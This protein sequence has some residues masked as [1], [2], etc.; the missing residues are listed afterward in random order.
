MEKA[1]QDLLKAS[2]LAGMAEVATG[3]LHNVGN[4]LNS[5]N[6]SVNYLGE[7]LRKSKVSSLVRA[8]ALLKENSPRLADYLT[9]DPKGK[10]LPGYL[11]DISSYLAAEN[12]TLAGKMDQ[13]KGHVE[14]V[15][16]IVAMQQD[17]AK[18]GGMVESVRVPDLVEDALRLNSTGLSRH[19]IE[20]RREFEAVPPILV[21]KHRVLQILVNLVR[22]AEHACASSETLPR[23]LVMRVESAEGRVRIGVADNGVG[24]PPENMVR[25]FNHGFTTRKDGHG[26][27]LHSCALTARELGG[28]LRAQSGGAGRG[29]TF[30]LDLP[31]QPLR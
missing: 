7:A 18:V 30:T 1:N 2:R 10:Q 5:V 12:E 26:F 15:K 27:G 24:I 20:V 8:T 21:D 22:N 31:I 23:L 4:V 9:A 14:H 13:L 6:V 29:A 3:I 19:G 28:A 17:Y 11:V 16:E 25:I